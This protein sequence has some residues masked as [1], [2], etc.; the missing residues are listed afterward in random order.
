METPE[1][2]L[3]FGFGGSLPSGRP[4][5]KPSRPVSAEG[6]KLVS[7][8]ISFLQSVACL[9]HFIDLTG[10]AD[11]GSTME[12]LPRL[13]GTNPSIDFPGEKT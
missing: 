6:V 3:T 4:R 13:S 7:I 11:P 10:S 8:D 9:N 2:L 12:F 1:P 5:K